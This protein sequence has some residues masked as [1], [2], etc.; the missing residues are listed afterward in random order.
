MYSAHVYIKAPGEERNK[1]FIAETSHESPLS[2]IGAVRRCWPAA[3][4]PHSARFVFF[5]R[6]ESVHVGVTLVGARSP[7]F[8]DVPAGSTPNHHDLSVAKKAREL[9][10]LKQKNNSKVS[11]DGWIYQNF[12]KN[13]I[14]NNGWRFRCRLNQLGGIFR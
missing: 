14:D 6:P 5:A 2:G 7:L 8:E 10:A 12:N 11:S 13:N 9:F 4:R 3:R 1:I